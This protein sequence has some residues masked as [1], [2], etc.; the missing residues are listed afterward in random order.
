[1][2]T[3][4]WQQLRNDFASE[5][6]IKWRVGQQTCPSEKKILA[7][8]F[9]KLLKKKEKLDKPNRNTMGWKKV[10]CWNFCQ[11]SVILFP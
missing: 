9:D 2:S 8:I 5:K 4:I 1:M 3:T 11:I 10:K 7:Y 6:C